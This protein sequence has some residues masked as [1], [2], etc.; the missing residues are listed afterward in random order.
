MI[1]LGHNDEFLSQAITYSSSREILLSFQKLN[2]CFSILCRI[3][4]TEKK[5]IK[6]ILAHHQCL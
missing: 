3:L 6:D 1:F 2:S 4:S 5:T